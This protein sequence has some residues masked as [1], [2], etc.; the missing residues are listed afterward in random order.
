[1]WC[2]RH[3]E[4]P[5]EPKRPVR[6]PLSAI[7]PKGKICIEHSASTAVKHSC[8]V[9]ESTIATDGSVVKSVQP[10][11]RG[12]KSK[13]KDRNETKTESPKS[14]ERCHCME[15]ESFVPNF[16]RCILPLPTVY[17]PRIVNRKRKFPRHTV[18]VISTCNYDERSLRYCA[19][20]HALANSNG[21]VWVYLKRV[22]EGKTI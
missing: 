2:V 14:K 17:V 7:L 15:S 5:R 10:N 6:C 11:T 12:T 19:G 13:P 3:R 22:H 1:M 21:S 20:K 16:K 8:C 18:I 4:H 9:G